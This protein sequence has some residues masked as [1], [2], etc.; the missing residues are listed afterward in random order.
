MEFPSDFRLFLA[1]QSLRRHSLLSEI[2]VPFTV[3]RSDAIEVMSGENVGALAERNALAKVR[4]AII[5]DGG[6]KGAFVLG[7]DTLVSL[8]RRVMGKPES[9][10]E[11]AEMLAALSG[12][13]H[14]VVSGVALA[15]L[16]GSQA[17]GDGGHISVG[18]ACTDVTFA[19]LDKKQI[20]AYVESGEWHGKAGA[21]AVQGLA[22][23][24]VRRIKGEYSN[25]VG[26][27]LHRLHGM[28]RE[29]GF[30]LMRRTWVG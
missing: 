25:V 20:A 8:G 2:G 5:P 24:F 19:A 18:K 23:L 27:P 28:F 7:T 29:L 9:V 15:R 10:E 13:R 22:G 11:A 3:V 21:Y 4:S 12:R 30:D 26:L 1:S 16:E 17:A 14:R 6:G